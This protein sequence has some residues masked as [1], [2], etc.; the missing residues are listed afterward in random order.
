M[1]RFRMHRIIRMLEHEKYAKVRKLYNTKKRYQKAFRDLAR[2]KVIKASFYDDELGDFILD[3]FAV[4]EYEYYRE[5]AWLALLEDFVW[6][7]AASVAS[8]NLLHLIN[9]I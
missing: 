5:G 3:N 8:A 7:V 1:V 9:A 4:A 2:L 6:G